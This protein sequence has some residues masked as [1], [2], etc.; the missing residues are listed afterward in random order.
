MH[1]AAT[2]TEADLHWAHTITH[3]F[4]RENGGDITDPAAHHAALA[5]L[6]M[7]EPRLLYLGSA[8]LLPDA[9]CREAL[10][11]LATIKRSLDW[12]GRPGVLAQ[13]RRCSCGVFRRL[14]PVP[15]PSP[16]WPDRELQVTIRNV[17][18]WAAETDPQAADELIQATLAQPGA[19]PTRMICFAAGMLADTLDDGNTWTGEWHPEVTTDVDLDLAVRT[20]ATLVAAARH[21]DR[22]T[23]V[24][25]LNA[26]RHPD[27]ARHHRRHQIL[28]QR[29]LT[30]LGDFLVDRARA[31]ARRFR[32]DG[33]GDLADPTV[34]QAAQGAVHTFDKFIF[35][36]MRTTARLDG[37]TYLQFV[38]QIIKA[39][40]EFE[41]A[42]R[43]TAGV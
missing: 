20:F 3:F 43:Y 19:F 12:A 32:Q 17:A 40:D 14:A 36:H 2:L 22:E 38:T 21:S 31:V 28:L 11:H 13:A 7:C 24:D 42:A 5:A 8:G 23:A 30:A 6:T 33:G 41:L 27:P 18:T 9:A 4:V 26:L 29:I 37:H 35:A 39:H 1:G 10:H 16:S 25:V 15:P 34:R